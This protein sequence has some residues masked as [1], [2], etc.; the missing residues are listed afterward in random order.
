MQ[1]R[2][3]GIEQARQDVTSARAGYYPQASASL[4][5]THL[6]EQPETSFGGV[7]VPTSPQDPVSL[8]LQL[9]Q[10]LYTFGRLRTGVALAENG[11]ASAQL[12][13]EQERWI[14]AGRI[15]RA[16][17]G[18]LLARQALLIQ[19]QTLQARQEALEVARRKFQVG[20]A[21]DYEVLQAEADLESFRPTLIG[22]AN[23]VDL[24]LITV[25]NL[26]N[27]PTGEAGEVELVGSLEVAPAAEP[28]RQALVTRA[29]AERFEARSLR[30]GQQAAALQERLARQAFYPTIGG[31]LNY[32]LSSGMDGDGDNLYWGEDSWDGNLSGGL[33]LSV[34]LSAWLPI[35]AERAGRRRAQL[36]QQDLALGLKALE[37]Q[38]QL[39]VDSALLAI[40]EQQQRLRSSQ[41]NITLARRLYDSA[42]EQYA[43]GVISSLELQNALLG[44]NGAQLGQLQSQYNYRLALLDLRDAVGGRRR[45]RQRRPAAGRRRHP[46]RCGS[47]GRRLHGK[48]VRRAP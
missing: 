30:Q 32:S 19:Q 16:F 42:R 36:A 48:Q 31:F 21:S 26:L 47:G 22:A 17:Y 27:L 18:F 10:P 41:T 8:S 14:L 39:Q 24:A 34:P 29:L 9:S 3:L 7:T 4:G 5:W 15:E 38:V 37:G 43:R 6:F 44:L 1:S 2:T 45:P 11:V 23:Q 35:S 13:L 25:K 28:D 12:S 46:G 33:S 40:R 20:V